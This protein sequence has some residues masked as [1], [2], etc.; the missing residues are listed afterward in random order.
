VSRDEPGQLPGR[1]DKLP[2]FSPALAK[3][4]C[5]WVR[6]RC[7]GDVRRREFIV[8]L[9]GAAVPWPLSARAQQPALPVI[10]FLNSASPDTYAP[11]IAAFRQGLREGGYVEGQNVTVEYRWAEGRYDRLPALAADLVN[12]KVSVIA[13]TSTPAARAA[14]AA[15]A[16]IPI[17]FE[18]S[19]DPVM[20]G[21][22]ASLSRPGGNVTGVNQLNSVLVAKRLGLL[23]ELVPTATIIGVLVNPT[24][25]R[26]ETQTRDMQEAAR[27]LGQQIRFV[28]ASTERE[29]DTAFASLVQNQAGA[30]IVGSDAF[31]NSRREQIVALAARHAVPAIYQLREFAAAGGLISYGTSQSDAYRLAGVYTSKILK[32]EKPEGL[33]VIQAARFEFVINLKTAKALGL[34]IPPLLLAS[35][36]EVIE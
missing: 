11:F 9:G 2:W 30:L 28:T 17:V 24:D 7:G 27:A 16:D 4:Y 31:F 33:A 14:K 23:H 15:T 32:G 12:R 36:D 22:V 6:G 18:M 29:I 8:V 20:L 25:S 26:A 10:G 3:R 35:A 21:L 1:F 5:P 13:A 19:G 34:E